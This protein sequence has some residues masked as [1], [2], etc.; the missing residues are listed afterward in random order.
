[1]SKLTLFDMC[2]ISNYITNKPSYLDV[3]STCKKFGLLNEYFNQFKAVAPFKDRDL[4]GD[5][6]I[7]DKENYLLF[8]YSDNTLSNKYDENKHITTIYCKF[9]DKFISDIYK[10]SIKLLKNWIKKNY[11]KKLLEIQDYELVLP[12]K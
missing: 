4:F 8:V 12:K 10:N 2:I 6:I 3:M 7:V 5:E 11:G 1:M 9:S